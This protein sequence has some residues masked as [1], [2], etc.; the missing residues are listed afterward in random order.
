MGKRRNVGLGIG[1]L[2]FL[3]L[4]VGALGWAC[5]QHRDLPAATATASLPAAMVAT[6][7]VHGET[8]EHLVVLLYVDLGPDDA[9]NLLR[10]YADLSTRQESL[11]VAQGPLDPPAPPATPDP[12]AL[13]G[14]LASALEG[15]LD[16]GGVRRGT[17][18]M[19]LR[20]QTSSTLLLGQMAR[21]A[22]D[23]AVD[24]DALFAQA[25]T[26]TE[27]VWANVGAACARVPRCELRPDP[28]KLVAEVRWDPILRP[29]HGPPKAED[30]HVLGPL[31]LE[32]TVLQGAAPAAVSVGT[33]YVP[34][35]ALALAGGGVV[36][37]ILLSVGLR[38]LGKEDVLSLPLVGLALS[39]LLL[40]AVQRWGP[41]PF[42]WLW[43]CAAYLLLYGGLMAWYARRIGTWLDRLSWL[44]PFLTLGT[45]SLYL[46][47]NVHLVTPS[48]E[49]L[50]QAVLRDESV[51][52]TPLVLKVAAKLLFA[53][54]CAWILV[55][56]LVEAYARRRR[57][58]FEE[59]HPEAAAKSALDLTAKERATLGP[60]GVAHLSREELLRE[61]I[62]ARP[63]DEAARL[64][65]RRKAPG[66]LLRTTTTLDAAPRS[67]RK[68]TLSE[69]DRRRYEAHLAM[70][71]ALR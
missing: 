46:L 68:E 28:P 13:S 27:G 61:G 53:G 1:I 32:R 65:G 21:I 39:L 6:V 37:G 59:A 30:A 62:L 33:V 15:L 22:R 31:L 66:G 67:A 60:L 34:L 26:L 24:P 4:T 9:R 3:L 29:L 49:G 11:S 8:G 52:A 63:R 55:L 2:L 45:A 58:R 23:P 12:D 35:D 69:D 17:P 71:K 16:E 5:V 54:F 7:L 51:L 56:L 57:R 20:V 64:F 10:A 70:L 38:L 18:V 14:D 40:A 19:E 41:I 47:T 36:L 25:D 44:A 43:M 48:P 42:L 50:V